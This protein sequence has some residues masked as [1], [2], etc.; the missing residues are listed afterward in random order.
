M[1]PDTNMKHCFLQQL[2]KM[3]FDFYMAVLQ[4]PLSHYHGYSLTQAMLVAAFFTIST[5][6]SL[7][8]S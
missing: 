3:F 2:L 6:R 5:Q 8:A 1:I 7:G 4:P